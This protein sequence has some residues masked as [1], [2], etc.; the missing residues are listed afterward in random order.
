MKTNK[1][2]RLI[3]LLFLVVGCDPL[4]EQKNMDMES[5]L[6]GKPPKT[7]MAIFA[8]PDD[9]TTIGPVLAKYAS[10]SDVHLVVATDGSFG[11]TN[12]AK[13]PAGDS[14]IAI[15]KI[16]TECACRELGIK[17]PHFLEA[18]DGLGLNGHN[19]FYDEVTQL[20]KRLADKI[21]ELQPDVILTF[22]PDG[23][24]GHPDHRLIGLLT[25]EILLRESWFDKIDLY[26]FAWTKEQTTKFPKDWGLGWAHEK[27][28]HTKID[29]SAKD[30]QMAFA[31]LQ[32]HQ[33]QFT[34]QEMTD[35]IQAEKNDTTNV[36]YFRKFVVDTIRRNGF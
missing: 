4:P 31:S 26:H 35:W 2:I 28:L 13:I 22:G 5:L 19:N 17:P 8:H 18:K 36:L 3:I 34:K 16:E 32:C 6:N 21:I 10:I 15:R 1:L 30:E 25:T 11:V 33:S 23:D 12:H 14:L 20:K 24:T 7:I 27:V 29:F 9:E